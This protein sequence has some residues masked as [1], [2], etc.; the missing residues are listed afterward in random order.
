MDS[1]PDDRGRKW[2]LV[3]GILLP[4]IVVVI[5]LLIEYHSGFFMKSP[6]PVSPL[7]TFEEYLNVYNQLRAEPNNEQTRRT[8]AQMQ[9]KRV[10]WVG[11]ITGVR[12]QPVAT[13]VL[14][15]SEVNWTHSNI[16]C[17][18]PRPPNEARDSI[19]GALSAFFDP[20]LAPV[21]ESLRQGQKVRVQGVLVAKGLM[22]EK[23]GV[24]N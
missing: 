23:I 13:E 2:L 24:V 1:N 14:L 21:F 4:I 18:N 5:G 9:G 16:L 12:G 6:P 19:S 3:S 7:T 20:A 10:D 22:I 8:I 11:Y 15:L 17:M